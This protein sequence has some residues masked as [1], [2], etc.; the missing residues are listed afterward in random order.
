MD[1]PY[2]VISSIGKSISN[3]I[4]YNVFRIFRRERSYLKKSSLNDCSAYNFNIYDLIL[5]ILVNL[6]NWYFD[7]DVQ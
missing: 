4:C 3:I 7:F 2:F 1:H 6:Y 5:L